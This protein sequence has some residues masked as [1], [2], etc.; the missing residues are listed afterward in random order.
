MATPAPTRVHQA[1]AFTPTLFVAFEWSVNTW[2]LGGTPGAAPRPRERHVAAGA[3]QTVLAEIR[4]AKSR[5]GLPE[6]ARGMSGSAAGREGL[7]LHRFCVSQGV[8][9]AVVAA[10]SRAVQRRS[11]R[12][13]TAR[14]AC[15]QAAHEAAAACGRGNAGLECRAGAQRGRCRPPPAPPGTP[16]DAARS[17][18]RAPSEQRAAGRRWHAQGVARGW[19]EAARGGPP[20]GWHVAARRLA[21]AGSGRG[22]RSSRSRSRAGAWR[23]RGARRGAPGKSGGWSRSASAPRGAGLGAIVRGSW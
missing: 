16:A 14:L 23:Q 21:R 19:G 15:A 2:Q 18:A 1:T 17:A 4:R 13:Q 8:E 7:W 20:V 12:A 10:A 22:R 9:H 3:C 6:A 11:R 5:L